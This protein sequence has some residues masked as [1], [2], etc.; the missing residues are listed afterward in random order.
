VQSTKKIKPKDV[1]EF[2]WD[3]KVEKKQNRTKVVDDKVRK[4]IIDEMK[5]IEKSTIM[6]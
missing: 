2:P 5:K 4:E 3:K 6:A 1:M